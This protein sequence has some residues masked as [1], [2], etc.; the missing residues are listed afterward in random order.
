MNKKGFIARAAVGVVGGALILGGAGAAI[1]DELGDHDVDVNVNIEALPPVGALTL[2]VAPGGANLTEVD[3]GDEDVR[4]FDGTLP[5]VTVSDD[6]EE[7]PAG[8]GWYVLGQASSLTADG[9]LSIGAENLGWLPKL[10]TENNGEVA[11]GPQVDTQ[12]DGGI[13]GVGLVGQELLTLA[14]NSGEAA[15]TGTWAAN[16]GLFLKTPKTVAPGAYSGTITLTL[17]EDDGQ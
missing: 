10:L 17:W 15:Q 5:T 11:E 2:S 4:Q 3:S 12:I 14:P 7:V 6:R 9:G 1:A 13:N 8:M 16:A